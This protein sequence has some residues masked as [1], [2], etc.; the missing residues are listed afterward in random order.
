MEITDKTVEHATESR[1]PRLKLRFTCP[2]CGGRD[3][4]ITLLCASYPTS[5][6]DWLDVDPDC[7][8]NSELI[9]R[10]PYGEH[11]SGSH[12]GL[13]FE[14]ASCGAIPTIEKDGEK[15]PVEDEAE[16]AEWLLKNCP[17]GDED[18][19]VTEDQRKGD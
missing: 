11:W 14:C 9:E 13:E 6:L 5:T 8:E 18:Q 16:L 2:S 15:Q 10:D 7:F 17:Q 3:M 1:K 19:I 12:D 4:R